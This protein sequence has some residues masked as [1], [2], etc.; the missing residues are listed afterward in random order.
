MQKTNVQAKVLMTTKSKSEIGWVINVTNKTDKIAFFIHP[1]IVVNG[2]EVLPSFWSANYF[3]LAPGESTTV[4]VSCP[5]QKLG[6]LNPVLKV[7]GW[8][9]EVQETELTK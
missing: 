6:N 1:S 2:E 8:N 4:N 3:T 7:S 9:V 5:V